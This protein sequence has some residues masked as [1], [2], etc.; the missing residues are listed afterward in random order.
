MSALPAEQSGAASEMVALARVVGQAMSVAIVGAVFVGLGGAAAGASLVA[1]QASQGTNVQGPDAV[2]LGAIHAALL[3]SAS[4]AAV[5]A[6]VSIVGRR[7]PSD[8]AQ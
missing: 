5:G 4:L 3:V 7:A 1:Q 6:L 8:A 2:F